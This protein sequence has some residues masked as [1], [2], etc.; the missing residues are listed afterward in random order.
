MAYEAKFYIGQVVQEVDDC[1]VVIKFL[2]RKGGDYYQWPKRDDVAT[3]ESKF[4]FTKAIISPKGKHFELKERLENMQK[5]FK[6]YKKKYFQPSCKDQNEVVC[7]ATIKPKSSFYFWP[8]DGDWLGKKQLKFGLELIKKHFTKK[9]K[10]LK[11]RTAPAKT[12][13]IQADG[14]CF[15]RSISYWLTGDE[16][17]YEKVRTILVSYMGEDEWKECGR[18]IVGRDIDEYLT[19]GRM[20]DSG[21]WAT[22]TEIHAMANFLLTTIFVYHTYDE[23]NYEWLP[24]YP[25]CDK[26]E[27]CIYLKNTGFHFEPVIA[28]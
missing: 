6:A 25:L 13:P 10:A 12:V 19:K 15:Y 24:H 14:N 22:E 18:N 1:N 26:Q 9:R 7:T 4:I 28:N 11:R 5:L 8:V 23:K 2:E 21:V 16:E 17:Q 3:V 27:K 20:N